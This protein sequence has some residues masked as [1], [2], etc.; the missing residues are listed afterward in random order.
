MATLKPAIMIITFFLQTA[1]SQTSVDYCL[2]LADAISICQLETP[3]FTVLPASQQASCLCGSTLGTI[4]WGP[5]TFDGIASLCA[6]EYATLDPTVA[7]AANN[8]SGVCTAF[9]IPSQPVIASS[10]PTPTTFN[11]GSTTQVN[12]RSDSQIVCSR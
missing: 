2:A 3:S 8:L 10:T 11:A 7:S 5:A 9:A 12:L 1:V 6:V 4:S